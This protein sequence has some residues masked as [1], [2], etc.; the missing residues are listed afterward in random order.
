M[1][2]PD[3]DTYK[4]SRGIYRTQSLFIETLTDTCRR[5]GHEAV[6]T[7]KDTD[8]GKYKSF[9]RLYMS[10]RDITGYKAAI[11]I[12]GSWKHFKKMFANHKFS[13]M[14][15]EWNEELEVMLRS[16]GISAIVEEANEGKSRVNAAKFLADRGWASKRGRPTKADVAR[17]RRVQAKIETSIGEDAHRILEVVG[18]SK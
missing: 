5:H 2:K 13:K 11:G 9:K 10:Y 1:T 17:E 15:A 14:L 3:P 18:G 7:L 12:L 16:E 4:D 6:F 8:Q